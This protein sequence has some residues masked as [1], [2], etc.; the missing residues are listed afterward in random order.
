MDET[1]AGDVELYI[2]VPA[3]IMIDAVHEYVEDWGCCRARFRCY[4][5]ERLALPA[6]TNGE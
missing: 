4:W 1:D 3:E 5:K 6:T 2:E